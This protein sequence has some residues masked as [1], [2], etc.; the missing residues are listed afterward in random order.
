MLVLRQILISEKGPNSYNEA[1]ITESVQKLTALLDSSAD[2]G[3]E[4]IVDTLVV[5]SSSENL[6][7]K[8]EIMSRVLLKS[9]Q[10]GDIIFNKVSAAVYSALRA[11]VLAG[12]GV[13]GRKLAEVALRKVGGVILLDRVVK[14]GE[15]L[16]KM[17]VVSG[18][19][20]SPWYRC[21]V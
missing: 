3:L 5:T 12:S 15:V 20:H 10:N 1:A 7:T 6:E 13:K 9:L 17:A 8:K 4:E 11:V 19:V 21:L 14:A 2:V 18:Q 16:T